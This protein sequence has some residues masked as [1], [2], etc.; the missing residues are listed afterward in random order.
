M[1][2]KESI[3]VVTVVAG[4]FAAGNWWVALIAIAFSVK[5]FVLLP[6]ERLAEFERELYRDTRV[7][8]TCKGMHNN[9]N[10]EYN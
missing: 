8:A 2:D 4:V 7:C 5:Y 6:A 1:I 9:E 3:T 10:N